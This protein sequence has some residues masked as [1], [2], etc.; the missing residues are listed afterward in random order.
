MNLTYSKTVSDFLETVTIEHDE[1]DRDK[2]IKN[3]N[4]LQAYQRDHSYRIWRS[5][6]LIRNHAP[7]NA[8]LRVLELGSAPY[9]FSALLLNDPNYEVIG[10]NVRAGVWPRKSDRT[11][12]VT[13]RLNYGQPVQI[14]SLPVYIFN[15][16]LDRFPFETAEFDVVI[17]AEVIEH[18][19][20]S[21]TNMLAESHRVLKPGGL[22]LLTTPNIND[23]HKTIR[24]VR[25]KSIS[26]KYSGYGVYGRHNREY[27]GAEL[28]ELTEACGYQVKQLLLKNVYRQF[29][30]WPPQN[31]LYSLL[32]STTRLP[33][34]YLINKREY[35]FLIAE[36]TGHYQYNYPQ[37][38]YYYP[39]LYENKKDE[40]TSSS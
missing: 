10:S 26:F 4:L 17:C 9:F 14:G 40:T 13:V 38:F 5:L 24:L 39:E 3:K 22:L 23:I 15:F 1:V 20:Y 28:K 19:A 29:N 35:I 16:E 2:L 30:Y 8:P 7:P 27:M 11:E 31:F 37:K 18:L 34:S 25:N 12:Q 36:S 33:F 32:L 6:Q 21:P